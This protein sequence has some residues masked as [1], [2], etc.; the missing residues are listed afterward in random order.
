[1]IDH[2]VFSQQDDGRL[3]DTRYWDELQMQRAAGQQQGQKKRKEE[4]EEEKM[5]V[6]R[7]E[8]LWPSSNHQLKKLQV[9]V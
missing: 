9:A 2:G 3:R 6:A 7:M 8:E 1:M 4:R 5:H